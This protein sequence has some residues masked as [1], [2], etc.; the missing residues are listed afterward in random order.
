MLK[1][2]IFA[3]TRREFI[4]IRFRYRTQ[5]SSG[6][7]ED[8]STKRNFIVLRSFMIFDFEQKVKRSVNLNQ[9]IFMKSVVSVEMWDLPFLRLMLLVQLFVALGGVRYETQP[10]FVSYSDTFQR[11]F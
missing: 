1:G 9:R 5:P 4:E 7:H 11:I 3:K 8:N 6:Y 2:K 10:T